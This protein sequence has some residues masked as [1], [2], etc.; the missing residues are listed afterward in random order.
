M[1]AAVVVIFDQLTKLWIMNTFSPY[2]IKP[3]IKGVFNLIFITNTGAAFGMLA[4]EQTLWRQV[5]FA[6]VAIIALVVLVHA[7]R[8]YRDRGMIYVS[9][10]GL[11]A[12][13][14]I[15]NLIDRV[16]FGHV[17]DFLDF[18]IK[19]HHWP[20]FNVADSAITVGVAFFL[21]ALWQEHREEPGKTEASSQ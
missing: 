5:F 21:L 1:I 7:Y 2:E 14:A 9:A 16:R 18:Y 17:I 19:K 10:I 6:V 13:G 8:E 12:G 20:A 4:G 15:G 11:V 3:V